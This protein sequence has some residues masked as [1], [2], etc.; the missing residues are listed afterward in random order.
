MRRPLFW[1]CAAGL[2]FLYLTS[3]YANSQTPLPAPGTVIV[4]QPTPSL[5]PGNG[6]LVIHEPG[7]APVVCITTPVP[8]TKSTQTVCK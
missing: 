1:W 7:K 4:I 8:N 6:K 3:N 2:A 5:P